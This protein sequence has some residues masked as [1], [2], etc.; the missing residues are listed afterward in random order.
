MPP[1]RET[2]S[3]LPDGSVAEAKIWWRTAPWRQ[4]RLE[5]KVTVPFSVT[6]CLEA[7]SHLVALALQLLQVGK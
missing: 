5:T 2:W 3:P 1:G 6:V 4:G 7:V